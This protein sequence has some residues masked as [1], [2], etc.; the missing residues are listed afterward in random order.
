[1]TEL[2]EAALRAEMVYQ[3]NAFIAVGLPAPKHLAYPFGTT[4]DAVKAIVSDYVLTARIFNGSVPEEAYYPMQKDVDKYALYCLY[5]TGMGTTRDF[6]LFKSRMLE[7]SIRGSAI[8]TNN[9]ESL[10]LTGIY[11]L[12]DIIDYA[13]LIGLDMVTISELYDLLD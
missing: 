13:Q 12:S 4:S 9:H 1:M 11:T 6:D 2:T 3:I 10:A 8:C 5:L 7:A